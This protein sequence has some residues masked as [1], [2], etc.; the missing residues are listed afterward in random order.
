MRSPPRCTLFGRHL[1]KRKISYRIRRQL[2]RP[3]SKGC[4]LN[5]HC[6]R[7]QQQEET[8]HLRVHQRQR[9]CT[10]TVADQ[11]IKAVNKDYILNLEQGNKELNGCN[12]LDLLTHVCSNYATMDNLLS[13]MQSQRRLRSHPT[14]T[15]WLISTPQNKKNDI[16][17][18]AIWKFLSPAQ[19]SN[20]QSTWAQRRPSTNWLP[21]SHAK[22]NR[23]WHGSKKRPLFN[24]TSKLSQIKQKE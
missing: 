2:D 24:V 22:E 14:W 1:H 23:R 11:F 15:S 7:N 8:C 16:F 3:N 4:L 10:R 9:G 18:Q 20:L 5:V 6:Q 12:F 21:S 13:T 19:H 17:S